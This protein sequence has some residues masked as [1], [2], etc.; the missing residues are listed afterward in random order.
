MPRQA[1]HAASLQ[2]I[3]PSTNK[4]VSFDAPIPDDFQSLLKKWEKY[5]EVI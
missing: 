5:I 3:H 2:F 4:K 1:L